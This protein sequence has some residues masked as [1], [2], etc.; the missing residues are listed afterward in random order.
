MKATYCL[1]KFLLNAFEH[2]YLSPQ[3]GMILE[4]QLNLV[5]VGSSLEKET[6]RSSSAT[7]F[8]ASE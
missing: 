6:T 8:F 3:I 2:I 1:I 5:L 4:K 7:Y